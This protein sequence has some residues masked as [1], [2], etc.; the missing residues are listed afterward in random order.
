MYSLMRKI[1]LIGLLLVS[2]PLACQKQAVQ[3]HRH[4]PTGISFPGSLGEMKRGEIT[5]FEK[6]EQGL[7]VGIGYAGPGHVVANIY[8]YNFRLRSIPDNVQ[9]E[10]V[11]SHFLQVESDIYAE[12]KKGKYMA[13]Q[14]LSEGLVPLGEA[15][16]AP[17]ALSSHFSFIAIDGVARLSHLYLA[18]YKNHFIKIRF[19]YPKEQESEGK[20]ALLRFLDELGRLL[21]NKTTN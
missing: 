13:V 9:S 16:P 21:S 20:E 7:G 18:V 8:V 17:R 11:M 15:V 3:S 1:G 6:R 2:L 12:E 5:D 4:S 10:P 19:T 14:K